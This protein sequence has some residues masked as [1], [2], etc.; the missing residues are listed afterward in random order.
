MN[1]EQQHPS[2]PAPQPDDQAAEAQ[3]APLPGTAAGETTEPLPDSE[4]R[5]Q[6]QTETPRIWVG[7]LSDYNNGILHGAWMDAARE[8][9]E[10]QADIATMLAGSPWTART[11]EPA[12]E[13]GVFD[14]DN[15]GACRI[16]QH[17]GLD[18]ISA[19]AKGI[20]QHGLA[21]AAWADVM[22]D[23]ELLP[24]FEEAYLGEYDSLEAYAEHLIDELGYD[25]LLDRVV[26]PALRPYVEFNTAGYAQDMWLNG[27][28]N[29]YYR[30]G[31]GVWIFDA[32]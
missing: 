7:S 24:G 5:E 6:D 12:E 3:P 13:W 25:E 20:A 21:F 28:I 23:P 32:H 31:G 26:P 17:E 22:E 27:E 29:V 8:P 30:S 16:A 10:I 2:E 9:D 18:W 11:G 14:T 1:H 4:Q 15:F 19:V